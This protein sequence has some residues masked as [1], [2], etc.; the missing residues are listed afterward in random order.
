MMKIV[1]S[2]IV[3][4]LLGPAGAVR[5]QNQEPAP[6]LLTP[7][8][9]KSYPNLEAQ[10]REFC[11]AYIRKDYQTMLE[12]TH[13]K[14]LECAGGKEK[15]LS[16]L[17]RGEELWQ[18]YGIEYLSWTPADSTQV[19]SDSGSLY[20]IVPTTVNRR[21]RGELSATDACLIGISSDEGQHWTFL[22]TSCVNLSSMF[23]NVAPRLR[24]CPER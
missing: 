8:I 1:Y 16:E 23:P 12:L 13:P 5:A 7:S 4:V 6:Q 20:A 18:S 17:V 10:A 24:I 15:L 9:F 3:L 22:P 11:E 2:V 19:I 21:V 14:M